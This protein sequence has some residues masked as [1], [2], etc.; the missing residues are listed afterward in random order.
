MK[1][2]GVGGA[3]TQ[4]SGEEFEDKTLNEF[5]ADLKTEGYLVTSV[6]HKKGN[7]N[8]SSIELEDGQH[9]RISLFFKAGLYTYFFE[10]QSIDYSKHFSLKLEP[11]TAIYSH[12]RRVLTIIEK[13][14][15]TG[16]GS[17]AEKLQ[18]CD[19][20]RMFYG[21]LCKELNIELDIVWQLGQYFED[22]GENLQSVFEYMESKG[23]SYYFHKIP[24]K[25]L[26][27]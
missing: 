20:K 17:V 4:K 21:T 7:K 14:Q 3:K 5:L 13:K 19:F 15:Q 6:I 18:T 10:P 2:G 27:I 12:K 1:K 26:R 23:S 25:E 8:P 9:N 11:D 24:I 16:S 22:T